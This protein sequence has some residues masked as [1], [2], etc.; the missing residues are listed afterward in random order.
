M[1]GGSFYFGMSGFG[2]D[3]ARYILYLVHIA[4]AAAVVNIFFLFPLYKPNSKS[5]LLEQNQDKVTLGGVRGYQDFRNPPTSAVSPLCTPE[6]RD[7]QR[8]GLVFTHAAIASTNGVAKFPNASSGTEYLGIGD[9]D[10]TQGKYECVEVPVYSLDYYVDKYVKG[11]GPINILMIDVEGY[12]FD[13]L[14]GASSA[15]DKTHYLEF[16]YH[17]SGNW[18][19]LHLQEA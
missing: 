7:L 17:Q 11:T 3:R 8:K 15:L 2:E 9:C 19:K 1:F 16:E 14:F 5:T 6:Q 10:R 12:D 13:V 18:G 4:F